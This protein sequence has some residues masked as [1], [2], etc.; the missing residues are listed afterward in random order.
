MGL[1]YRVSLGQHKIN[2]PLEAHDAII[3]CQY[4]LCLS[5]LWNHQ[6]LN[7][8]ESQKKQK[9]EKYVGSINRKTATLGL[10]R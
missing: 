5:G 10:T 6:S 2:V 1:N 4:L 9:A 7:L 8:S 3:Q